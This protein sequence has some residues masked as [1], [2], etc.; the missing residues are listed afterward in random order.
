M[1]KDLKLQGAL[2]ERKSLLRKLRKDQK[3]FFIYTPGI[4]A[5]V[6]DLIAWMKLRHKRY[7]KRKGGL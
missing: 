6:G 4:K 7:R 1:T 2:I 5:Y 3:D